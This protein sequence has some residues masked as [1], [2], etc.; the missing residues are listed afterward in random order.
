[1]TNQT[2]AAFPEEKQDLFNEPNYEYATF[3]QRFFA[4]FIDGILLL[5]PGFIF[6]YIFRENFIN[7]FIASLIT[8]WLYAAIMESGPW[9]ATFGKRS[10]DIKVVD[11]NGQRISFGQATGR[12]FGKYISTLILLIGYFMMLWDEK[13]QTLHDKMAGTLIVKGEA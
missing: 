11:M 8:H 6:L 3:W 10:L 9:Q 1:M 5:I 4:S 2:I 12:H 13:K 7:R